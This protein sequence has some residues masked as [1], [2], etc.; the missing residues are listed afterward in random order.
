MIPPH[1]RFAYLLELALSPPTGASTA[2]PAQMD[3]ARPSVELALSPPTGASTPLT[4][5]MTTRRGLIE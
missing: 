4:R 3:A 5:E 2:D 1:R